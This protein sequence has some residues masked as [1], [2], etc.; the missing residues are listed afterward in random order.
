MQNEIKIKDVVGRIENFQ[1]LIA[2]MSLVPFEDKYYILDGTLDCFFEYLLEG[3]D[4]E[5]FK[6]QTESI[7]EDFKLCKEDATLYKE[8]IES[9]ITGKVWQHGYQLIH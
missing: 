7:S 5:R 3:K 1:H 4:K 8:A 2:G 9:M 6:M